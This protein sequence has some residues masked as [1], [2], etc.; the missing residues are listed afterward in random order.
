MLPVT[1]FKFAY[2]LPGNKIGLIIFFIDFVQ[3]CAHR[4]SQNVFLHW[5]ANNRRRPFS[6]ANAAISTQNACRHSN[7]AAFPRLVLWDRV[8]LSAFLRTPDPVMFSKNKRLVVTHLEGM[9]YC[10][11]VRKLSGLVVC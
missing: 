3:R 7:R 11:S 10:T 9:P 2:K 5:E 1:K 8:P 6:V 4:R